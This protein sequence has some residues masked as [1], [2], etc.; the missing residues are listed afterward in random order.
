M[1]ASLN[2]LEVFGTLSGLKINHEKTKIIWIGKK[3]RSKEKLKLPVKLNWGEENFKLL[4][5]EFS[6]NLTTIPD[7]N[8]DKAVAKVN[9]IINL[10]K[11]RSLTPIGKI[12]VIKTL[13]LSQFNHLFSSVVTPTQTLDKINK[14]FFKFLWDGKPDKIRRNTMYISPRAR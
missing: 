9:S 14:I 13:L 6:V 1:Q 2:I 7:I 11:N 10:W 5:L 4:G 12:T 3:K 8:F